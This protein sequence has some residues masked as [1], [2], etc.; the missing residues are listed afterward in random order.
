MDE[1][2]PGVMDSEHLVFGYVFAVANRL[3]RV[4]DAVMPEVTAKQW[5]LLVTLSRFT[6]P[7]TLGE[8]AK[9]ADTSHQNTRQILDK[10]AVKG[11]V[12]LVPDETDGRAS[13]VVATERVAQWGQKTAS[14]SRRFMTQMYAGLNEE[15][16]AIVAS[17]LMRIHEA[18]ANMDGK[19]K[20]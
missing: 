1:E 5:W 16:L 7:P 20:K 9:A 17:G 6:E 12:E 2:P 19:D 18:L 3:Q 13:R 8:L 10:L 15:E 14:E 4:L 11:F